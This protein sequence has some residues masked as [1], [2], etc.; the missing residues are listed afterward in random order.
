MGDRH[1][2]QICGPGT[3]ESNVYQRTLDYP[4]EWHNGFHVWL[5]TEVLVMVRWEQVKRLAC[6]FYYR[7]ITSRSCE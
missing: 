5:D 3:V 4:D 6:D 1:Q 7:A 2:R